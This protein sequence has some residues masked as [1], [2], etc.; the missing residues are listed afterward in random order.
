VISANLTQFKDIQATVGQD[1]CILKELDLA[2][3]LIENLLHRARNGE[4]EA[5]L[6][7]RQKAE[8]DDV[9]AMAALGMLFDYAV[10][11]SVEVNLKTA[12]YWYT[13]AAKAG[14][15]L[16]QLCL[17]NMCHYGEGGPEDL[18]S[19]FEWYLKAAEQ[20][21]PESQ[22][23]VGR[24]YQQGISVAIDLTAAE[25][26][27]RRAIKNGHELAATN[28]AM[29]IL[30]RDVPGRGHE[31]TVDLLSFAASKGD[32]VAFLVLGQLF[33]GRPPGVVE[34]NVE[35]ALSSFCVAYSLLPRGDNR[36][37]AAKL[38]DLILEK[39]PGSEDRAK[40]K[41]ARLI[42]EMGLNPPN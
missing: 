20:G 15:A 24:F 25:R 30:R 11:S 4:T 22:M 32:G 12:R 34:N 6:Q 42:E 26:W 39:N 18:E 28:L 40:R 21:E 37:Q 31:E 5:L 33:I 3:E 7:L 41:A 14:S 36:D 16:A 27:Y 19:A 38:R 13:R 17:G 9:A 10:S 8:N 1:S 29:M 23:H 2:E 35:K